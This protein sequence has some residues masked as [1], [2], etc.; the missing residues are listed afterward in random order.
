MQQGCSYVTWLSFTAPGVMFCFWVTCLALLGTAWQTERML[1]VGE[2]GE[3]FALPSPPP[4]YLLK[5]QSWW[6]SPTLHFKVLYT[7]NQKT[8]TTQKK[9]LEMMCI[10]LLP[11]RF[12]IKSYGLICDHGI[13]FLNPGLK[14]HSCLPPPLAPHP[15]LYIALQLFIPCR[16]CVRSGLQKTRKTKSVSLNSAK[17]DFIMR[18]CVEHLIFYIV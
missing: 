11:A 5:H 8:K 9:I 12:N 15:H 2:W 17:S 10:S 16:V 1:G 13:L 7:S 3:C 4:F 14:E 6:Q 18:F